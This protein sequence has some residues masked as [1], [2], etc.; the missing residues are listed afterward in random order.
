M[1]ANKFTKGI[2]YFTEGKETVVIMYTFGIL[3]H[4]IGTKQRRYLYELLLTYVNYFE[5][6]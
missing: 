1:V 3:L 2:D 4:T 5:I 6:G